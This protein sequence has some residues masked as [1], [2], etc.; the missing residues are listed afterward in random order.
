M[1]NL[2]IALKFVASF[3]GLLLL[4]AV[5]AL[6][7]V[8][9]IKGIVGNA[10]EVIDGNKLRGD[11]VQKEV[12]HLNWANKVNALLVDDHITELDVQTDPHKCAFGVWLYGE[13][14]QQAEALIPALQGTLGKIEKPHSDLHASAEEIDEVFKQADPELPAILKTRII[15][16]L[17]WADRFRDTFLENKEK[18]H[19][20]T[21]PTK[22][23]LGKWM[24]SEE[25]QKIYKNA[26]QD[27]RELWDG[28]VPVHAKLHES[29]VPVI[30][31][32]AQTNPGLK[33]HLLNVL[34]DHKTWAEK[35]SDGITAGNAD[36]GVQT[37]HTK[38]AYGKFLNSQELADMMSN[39]SALGT[40]IE[41]S[42]EPHKK[43][44]ESAIAIASALQKGNKTEAVSIFNSK[45]EKALEEVEANLKQAIQAVDSRDKAQHAAM[46][47]FRDNI[48]P[49]LHETLELLDEMTEEAEYELN[50]MH[51]A[52]I[53]FA[54][55]TE[56]NLHSV[57]ELLAEVRHTVD[58]YMMTDE[59]M[60]AA[61]SKTNMVVIVISV[62]ALGVGLMLAFFMSRSITV[63][64]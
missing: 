42:K 7:S 16:H 35:V 15:D 24:Q 39:N 9:G 55:Q 45:T 2:S 23:G 63:P 43:L 11:M 29:A 17:N 21:D 25:A 20:Q 44:H 12:D 30:N 18:L 47:L 10:G 36:L 49:L 40:A 56:P 38:C 58:E 54:S 27:F 41:Q 26:G 31:V 53:I 34:L 5:V 32:Y 6:W 22:C 48:L 3:G 50:G 52:N 4:L 8:F 13:G 60:I 64:L 28:M 51:E 14:R 62:I 61:A 19:V 1:K 46:M 33:E 37:D 57:Q 59:V